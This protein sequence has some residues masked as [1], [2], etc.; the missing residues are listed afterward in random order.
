MTI[1]KQGLK[2]PVG[3]GGMERAF[4]PKQHDTGSI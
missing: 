3:A 2:L 1:W 4:N